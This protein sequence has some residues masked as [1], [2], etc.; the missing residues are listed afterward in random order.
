MPSSPVRVANPVVSSAE[1]VLEVNLFFFHPE[2]GWTDDGNPSKQTL[3]KSI[4]VQSKR[5]LNSLV[6]HSRTFIIKAERAGQIFQKL[7]SESYTPRTWRT[8]PLHICPPEPYDPTN[9]DTIA[10]LNWIFLISS[11]NFSFWSEREGRPD[12]YG[13][14]WRTSWCSESRKVHTGYWS[15]LAA[16][17]RGKQYTSK[18]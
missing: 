14:E 13:V 17:N 18:F 4:T 8:H 1:F 3:S 10:C 7:S 11:L 15:L 12:K 16:L 5:P 9:A 2:D 6:K